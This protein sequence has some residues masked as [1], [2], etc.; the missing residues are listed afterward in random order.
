M[1]NIVKFDLEEHVRLWRLELQNSESFRAENVSELETHLRDSVA[2]LEGRG[3]SRA[4]AFLIARTRLGKAEAIA[5][6]FEAVNGLSIWRTRALWMVAGILVFSA[7]RNAAGLAS[8]LAMTGGALVS[9]NGFAIGWLGL[10]VRGLVI[11]GCCA[12]AWR[13]LQCRESGP[14]RFSGNPNRWAAGLFAILFMLQCAALVAPALVARVGSPV[15][16][17]QIFALGNW[18]AILFEFL[19]TGGLVIALVRLSAR[20]VRKSAPFPPALL[21]A[22]I[23]SLA[24]SGCGDP[25]PTKAAVP[26]ANKTSLEKA[27]FSWTEGDKKSAVEA[28]LRLDWKKD[29]LFSSGS[30]LRYSEAEF[31]ALPQAVREK[32]NQPMLDQVQAL[33]TLC[34][35]VAESGREMRKNG[36]KAGAENCFN[37]L[38]KC[39]KAL[40]QPGSLALVQ[41]VGK[42]MTKLAEKE[43]GAR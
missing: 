9:Q 13:S 21:L 28:F 14:G 38:A 32:I 35:G 42:A 27:M 1:A 29:T 6:D 34:A 20:G 18:G 36:D 37:Q 3:L 4:E 19:L 43:L 40:E 5:G 24:A 23:C 39:G 33:K 8:W 25:A 12:L 41:M 11:L 16:L 2:T 30:V 22:A 7:I 26:A 31:A 15:V 10:A 17:G